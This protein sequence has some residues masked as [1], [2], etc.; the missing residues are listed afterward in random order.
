MYKYLRLKHFW[1]GIYED[2]NEVYNNCVTCQTEFRLPRK[3]EYKKILSKHVFYIVSLEA[4]SLLLTTF[5]KKKILL[6]A[7]IILQ[8]GL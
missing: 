7:F 4:I 5:E 6:L 8:N 1:D 3:F 2:I